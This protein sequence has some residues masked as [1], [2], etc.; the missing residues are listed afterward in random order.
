M[1]NIPK[2]PEKEDL[3]Y[4]ERSILLMIVEQFQSSRYLKYLTLILVVLA[5]LAS[6]GKTLLK[7]LFAKQFI[8]SYQPPAVNEQPYIPQDLLIRQAGI[9]P[10]A[11]STYSGYGQFVNPNPE[12]SARRIG[13]KFV[14]RNSE[15]EITSEHLGQDFLFPGESHFVIVPEL[16]FETAP[17][18]VE[19]VIESVNWTRWQPSVNPELSIIQQKSGTSPEGNFFVEGLLKNSTA[20]Q[21]KKVAVEI[22]VFD[23]ANKSLVAVNSTMRD[24]LKPYESRYFRVLWPKPLEE[25]LGQIQILARINAFEPVIFYGSETKLPA[26]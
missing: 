2:I 20:F 17:S 16:E 13:Y 5:V 24:D 26:R 22:L 7:D 3:V 19:L 6:P 9:L 4:K 1:L 21:I 18:R 25:N 12:I 10:V 15:G 14:F 8:A 23:A 11:E